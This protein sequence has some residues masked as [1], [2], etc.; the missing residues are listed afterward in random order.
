MVRISFKCSSC[1]N[2]SKILISLIFLFHYFLKYEN[3]EFQINFKTV[4]AYCHWCFQSFSWDLLLNFLSQDVS[5][6]RAAPGISKYSDLDGAS[7]CPT[8]MWLFSSFSLLIHRAAKKPFQ[9]SM[10]LEWPCCSPPGHFF[11]LPPFTS[12]LK[13]VEWGTA[14]KLTPLEGEAS[15]ASRWPPWFWG[16]SFHS[17]YQ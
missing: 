12:S 16:A 9:R 3:Y 10:P 17:S 2:T 11:M 8:L 15:A 7:S 6:Y 13:W 1:K 14:T 5:M 4:I